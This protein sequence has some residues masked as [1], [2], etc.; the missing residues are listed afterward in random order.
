MWLLRQCGQP[1]TEC[2]HKVMELLFEFVP[3]LPGMYITACVNS[4]LLA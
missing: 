4:L 2:R 1:Q 3:L